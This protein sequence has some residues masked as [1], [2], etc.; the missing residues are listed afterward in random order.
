MSDDRQMETANNGAVARTENRAPSVRREGVDRSGRDGGG[1][2]GT[3]RR[4]HGCLSDRKDG[5]RPACPG[6]AKVRRGQI[7]DLEIARLTIR[8]LTIERIR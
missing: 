5:D 3:R 2:A 4:C 7:D 6:R 1:G 8:E